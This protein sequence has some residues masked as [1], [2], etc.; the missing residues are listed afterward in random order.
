MITQGIKI[1]IQETLFSN[2]DQKVYAVI[3]G[4]SVKGLLK[5]LRKHKPQNCCLFIGD[6]H[7]EI[8][9]TAPYLVL[10]EEGS[11][12]TDWIIE[13]WGKHFGIFALASKDLR[14]KEIRKH[15][16][17]FLLVCDTEGRKLYF[18][19]Y[20]PRVLQ[21]YLPTCNSEETQILF[22]PLE[23]YVV[24][25][26]EANTIVHFWVEQGRLRS[27]VISL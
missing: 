3:D 19:Y 7:P 18:R 5:Q 1:K 2:P 23:S 14:F 9:Q 6:L 25:G 20:D 24:E 8:V 27:T 17:K 22:G 26:S 15:F 13:A 10:I 21:V 12:F 4:A 16:R 11:P